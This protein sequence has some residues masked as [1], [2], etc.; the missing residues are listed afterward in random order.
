MERLRTWLGEHAEQVSDSDVRLLR[1]LKIGEEFGE[2]AEA[3]HGAMGANPAR[4]RP[5]RATT[6]IRNCAM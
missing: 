4:G 2:A 5:T 6:S 1:S 3:L